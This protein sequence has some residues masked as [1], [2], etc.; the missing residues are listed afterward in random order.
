MKPGLTIEI[1]S[2][3]DRDE[4]VAEV[5]AGR[6]QFAEL[7]KEGDGLVLQVFSPPQGGA[8]DL[9]FEQVLKALATAR[10]RLEGDK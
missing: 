10:D 2:V 6:D 4:L 8:W 5:W 7:R 1:A 3:P 9:A